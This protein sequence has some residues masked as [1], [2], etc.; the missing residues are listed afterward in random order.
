MARSEKVNARMRE[1]SRRTIIDNC[2]QLF[3]EHGYYQCRMSDI[4][5]AAGMSQGN[6]YWYFDGKEAILQAIL[7]EG[8]A[9]IEQMLVA[10]SQAEG[11]PADKLDHLFSQSVQLYEQQQ[12]F[13]RLLISL[14]S[15]S[16]GE[17][18]AGLGF[19]LPEIGMAFHTAIRPL[20]NEAILDGT[21]ADADPD[22]LAMLYFS[23]FNG[24]L[25]TYGEDWRMIPE[26]NLHQSLMRMLGRWL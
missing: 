20:F 25:I 6:V 18:V 4:A 19:N 23:F 2:K 9:R 16:G 13:M 12:Y 24:L 22:Q 10:V 17:G 21:L 1:E 26:G 15:H 11:S 5:E 8:F 14:L 7:E 3:A